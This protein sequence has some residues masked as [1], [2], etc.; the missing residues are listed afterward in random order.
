MNT[1][2]TIVGPV[3]PPHW[4]PRGSRQFRIEV[5]AAALVLAARTFDVTL[6]RDYARWVAADGLARSDRVGMTPVEGGVIIHTAPTNTD[7]LPV[8][9]GC[10]GRNGQYT[11]T[12]QRWQPPTPTPEPEPSPPIM[13][14]DL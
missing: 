5:T 2:P 7:E 3:E 13:R 14:V 1:N 10:A 11:R 12:G 8:L 9:L 6:T 4:R